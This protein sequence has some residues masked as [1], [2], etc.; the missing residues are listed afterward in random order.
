MEMSGQLH[1]PAAL[2]PGKER[3]LGGPQTPSGRG[4]EEKNFQPLPG[5]EPLIIQPLAQR[6]TT[7]L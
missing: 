7:E 3:R 6:Y 2:S 5:L 1:V 4:D